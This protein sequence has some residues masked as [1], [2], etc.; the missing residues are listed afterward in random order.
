MAFAELFSVNNFSSEL[1]LLFFFVFASHM[2]H[3]ED[4]KGCDYKFSRGATE[5]LCLKVT[6]IFF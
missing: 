2:L 5:I 3:H 6:L 1:F 4:F